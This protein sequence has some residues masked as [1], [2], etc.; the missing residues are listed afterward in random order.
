MP[1]KSESI[2][3]KIAQ[4]LTKNYGYSFDPFT[5][6]M[7]AGVIINIIRLVYECRK[8]KE[9]RVAMLRSPSLIE[10]I[11]LRRHIGKACLGTD[12]KSQDLYRELVGWNLSTAEI[13]GLFKEVEKND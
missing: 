12:I 4:K 9:E 2:A 7:I 13:E 5:I 8:D 6:I 11:V 10:K 1:N 3:N